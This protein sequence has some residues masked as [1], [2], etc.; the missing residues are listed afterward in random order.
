[1]PAKRRKLQ[2]VSLVPLAWLEPVFARQRQTGPGFA[3]V[4]AV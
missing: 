4:A 3:E 1:M 2:Q